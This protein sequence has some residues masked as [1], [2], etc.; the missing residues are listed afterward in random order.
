MTRQLTR[1]C[2]LT[3]AQSIL[4]NLVSDSDQKW[5]T[6]VGHH[7]REGSSFR[8]RSAASLGDL[9]GG[10]H[11]KRRE[12]H[13]KLRQIL[14]Q[15]VERLESGTL[16]HATNKPQ[17][18][19]VTSSEGDSGGVLCVF[20]FVCRFRLREMALLSWDV[21]CLFSILPPPSSLYLQ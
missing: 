15:E 7:L 2:K 20:H 4:K 16:T 5:E 13:S 19:C 11:K 12:I 9:G 1:Y 14:K 18:F 3:G 6:V 10:M 17:P 21:F 8:R